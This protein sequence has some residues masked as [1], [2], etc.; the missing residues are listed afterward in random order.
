MKLGS[1]REG[2]QGA[3]EK[4]VDEEKAMLGSNLSE[5]DLGNGLTD[6]QAVEKIMNDLEE[7]LQLKEDHFKA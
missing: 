4:I 1:F 2:G 6:A 3:S 5:L 7:L